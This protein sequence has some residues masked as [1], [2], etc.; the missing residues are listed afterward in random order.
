M[1]GEQNANLHWIISSLF[2][3]IDEKKPQEQLQLYNGTLHQ[4]GYKATT[5]QLTIFIQPATITNIWPILN[6]QSFS[7][8]FKCGFSQAD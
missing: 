8:A 5:Y 4:W 7:L 6:R 3:R 2:E 1:A